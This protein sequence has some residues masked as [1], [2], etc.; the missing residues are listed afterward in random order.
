MSEKAPYGVFLFHASAKKNWE[1]VIEINDFNSYE[2]KI[3]LS[4]PQ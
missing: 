1:S 4:K 2:M 3:T